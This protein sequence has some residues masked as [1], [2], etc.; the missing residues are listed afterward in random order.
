[1]KE[2]GKLQRRI[3]ELESKNWRGGRKS[4]EEKQRDEGI[5]KRVREIERKL[6][7]KERE[8]RRRNVVMKISEGRTREAVEEILKDIEVEGRIERIRK[9]KEN[10]ER[11][12]ET[13]WVR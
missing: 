7:M 6:E 5:E 10:V 2:R 8:E 9:L 3:K 11:G 13:I 4:G 1:M 12:T